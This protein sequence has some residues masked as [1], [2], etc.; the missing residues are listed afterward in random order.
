MVTH[1][2]ENNVTLGIV[3]SLNLANC[4]LTKGHLLLFQKRPE[5]AQSH[6]PGR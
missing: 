3:Y 4:I 5:N 6:S 2:K 1:G